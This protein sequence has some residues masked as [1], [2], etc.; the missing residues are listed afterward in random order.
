[1]M[2]ESAGKT[3]PTSTRTPTK[4]WCGNSDGKQGWK[5]K[6]IDW[7]W[8]GSSWQRVPNKNFMEE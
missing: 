1:M 4:Q 8:N 3:T 5:T 2:K 6:S 7:A